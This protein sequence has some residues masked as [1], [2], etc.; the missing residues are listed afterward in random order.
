MNKKE[1]KS[2]LDAQILEIKKY[3]WI[4]S[5]KA[6]RDLGRKAEID[7]IMKYAKDYREFWERNRVNK[8][9]WAT[10]DYHQFV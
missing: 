10:Y 2:F 8:E 3:R 6:K 1:F 5:E 9:E 7:W 4:E